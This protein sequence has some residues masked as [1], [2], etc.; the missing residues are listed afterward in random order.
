MFKKVPG[1]STLML[2]SY[3][4]DN[5]MYAIQLPPVGFGVNVATGQLEQTDTIS[6]SDIPEEQYWQRTELPDWWDDR[7]D[8]EAHKQKEDPDYSDEELDEIR[9]REWRRRLC[10]VWM[11]NYNPKK[12]KSEL[13]YIYGLHYFYMNWW[14]IDI[15]YPNFRIVDRDSF[16]ILGYC[17]EDPDCLG[18]VEVTKRKNGKCLAKDTPI[19]MYD[20]SVK[21]VQDVH[22]GDLV[23]GDDST[24]RLAYGITTGRE[25]MYRITPN[26]GNGFTCNESHILSLIWNNTFK[27]SVYGWEKGDVVNISVKEY[28]ALKFWEKDHLC[29]YR[30]GWGNYP[31]VKHKIPPYILGLYLGDGCKTFGSITTNDDEIV[32]AITDYAD[33]LG[34]KITKVGDITYKPVQKGAVKNDICA[35]Y[36]ENWS[37]NPYR[38]GLRDL[39]V[40]KNKHIPRE[41]LIDS[42]ENRLQLLAGLIDTD[43]HLCRI[44]G[45][46][47]CY[48]IT[49]KN[50]RLAN[51]IVELAQ[52]LGFFASI[53]EK[54]ARM[55][56]KDWSVYKCPVY[57]IGIYGEL[58][59]IPC[60]VERKI[61][62]KGI[63]RKHSQRT[64]FKV[65]DVGEGDYYGFAVDDNHLFLLADGTVVHNTYRAG[66]FLYEYISR[67]SDT[68]GGVQSKTDDDA[69]EMY[70]KAVM[71]PWTELPEFFRPIYDTTK[72][73]RPEKGLYFKKSS[74]RGKTA[75][76]RSNVK[77]LNSFIDF[78]NALDKAYDGPRLQRYVSDESGKLDKKFDIEERQ[79]VVR[80]TT[81]VDHEFQG[82]HLYTTTVEDMASAGSKFESVWKNSNPAKR[83]G[84]NQTITG[85]YRYFI[86]G[87]R[88]GKVDKYGYT[89][90]EKNKK[91][92][93]NQLAA[94]INDPVA[95]ASHVRKNPPTIRHAFWRDAGQCM[96]NATKL[97]RR[98]EELSMME[99]YNQRGNFVWKD[100]VRDSHVVWEPNKNGRWKIC[101]IFSDSAKS[102]NVVNRGGLWYPKNEFSFI[103]GLDPFQ[104]DAVQ[105]TNRR[106][107]AASYV[108]KRYDIM[109]NDPLYN[110]AF[111]SQYIYRQPTS[112]MM[113]EDM[114]LQ[115]R[116]FGCGLLIEYNKAGSL[117]SYF[118]ARGYSNFLIQLPA[119]NEPGIPS[120][121]ENKQILSELTEEY[122]ESKI[123][124][125]YFDELIDSWLDFNIAE[126]EKYDE[127]MGAGWTL[128]A[129]MRKVV[130]PNR[131]KMT[132]ISDVLRTYKVKG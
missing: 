74:R 59:D 131:G 12:G 70:I 66:C 84:N 6:R 27:H 119:Y 51:D 75:M 40:L 5:Y 55:R 94:I 109:E 33:D 100:G 130:N 124:I 79:R 15:G 125:V 48:E 43:G 1:G 8:E 23:M 41:Y 113:H 92:L 132:E 107:N 105:N 129:N 4:E 36:L 106:S 103:S 68:H 89:D 87:F 32:D 108:L 76:Q 69:V 13:I 20:G 82:K 14:K 2:N 61:A 104:Q 90:E 111:V 116:Y 24:P 88:T 126:T 112:A 86:P 95:W 30:K 118:Q 60:R 77:A 10:G 38:Q 49:Q 53:Y 3:D 58:K 72:G 110:G 7:I 17:I 39:D 120:T 73:D 19:R 16:Y 45:R 35:A 25:K 37:I 18:L 54:E 78:K 52:S 98:R 117:K 122:I 128:V 44:N 71:Q 57:R 96:Y 34:L 101:W 81:D 91:I 80:Y 65:E 93:E 46:E 99:N 21:M 47:N 102:N 115:C 50:Q 42:K 63:R 64:G 85:L 9:D 31:E 83:D 123:D 22:E 56:R 121:P 67:S 97:N 29:L 26:K 62:S 11:W 28:L 127:V 114:I